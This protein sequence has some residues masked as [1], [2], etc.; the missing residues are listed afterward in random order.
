MKKVLSLLLTAVLLLSCLAVTAVS[1]HAATKLRPGYYLVGTFNNWSLDKD[2][3]MS[4]PDSIERYVLSQKKLSAGDELKIV[5]SD[6]GISKSTWYPDSGPTTNYIVHEDSYYNIEFS[7]NTGYSLSDWA[8]Q[9]LV[10]PCD[11]PTDIPDPTEPEPK[12]LTKELWESGADLTA[13]DIEEAANEQYNS[14][15]YFFSDDITLYRS[16]RFNCTPAYIVDFGVKGYGIYCEVITEEHFGD[17]LFWS[18]SSYEPSIFVDNQ[19]Y[20]LT[21]A[22]QLGVLTE[23]ML[24]ELVEANYR[25]GDDYGYPSCWIRRNIKGDADGDGDVSVIDATVIQRADARIIGE[26]DFYKPLGDVDGDG[27]ANVI[28][29]TLIQRHNVGL[30][31]FE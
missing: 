30:Y 11:P 13:E 2:Y 20:T 22:Y 8:W 24:A 12:N 1:A 16:Y 3:R 19:L 23:E 27:I 7:I 5:Y 18:S 31:S 9:L 15:I 29:A 21:Q 6:D 25:G 17:Y 28:D 14:R 4:Q 10:E 26:D